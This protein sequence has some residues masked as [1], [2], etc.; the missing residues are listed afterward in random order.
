MWAKQL[1]II[2]LLDEQLCRID[3]FKFLKKYKLKINATEKSNS[4]V[5]ENGNF[6]FADT[7]EV[8][9]YEDELMAA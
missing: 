3:G 1:L 8:Y 5:D 7:D 6:Y 4:F 9:A 2:L